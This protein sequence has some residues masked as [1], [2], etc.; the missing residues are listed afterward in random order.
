MKPGIITSQAEPSA[1]LIMR[2]GS[3]KHKKLI[4]PSHLY[5]E[6]KLF[7]P[8]P[9]IEE[10]LQEA[11]PLPNHPPE[12]EKIKNAIFSPTNLKIKRSSSQKSIRFC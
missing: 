11:S 3:P 12:I 6:R 1:K 10:S 4:I 2:I 5:S 9:K 8:D 7:S